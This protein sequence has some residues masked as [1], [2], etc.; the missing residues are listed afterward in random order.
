[1]IDEL[2]AVVR[3]APRSGNGRIVAISSNAA[4]THLRALLGTKGETLST[5]EQ[6]LDVRDLLGV[7]R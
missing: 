5:I 6:F 7:H 3:V 1:M 4:I 2:A